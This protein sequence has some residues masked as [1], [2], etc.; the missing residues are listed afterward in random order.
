MGW[1]RWG[2]ASAYISRPLWLDSDGL[3]RSFAHA[4]QN[5]SFQIKLTSASATATAAA[6]T[7]AVTSMA[8]ADSRSSPAAALAL[9]LGCDC[10]LLQR[11]R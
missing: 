11:L 8:M 9:Q 10:S 6:T 4:S 1:R 3:E 2:K 7:A 5:C